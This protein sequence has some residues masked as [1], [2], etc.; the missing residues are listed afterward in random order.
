MFFLPLRARYTGYIF[1]GLKK[2]KM[3]ITQKSSFKII[4]NSLNQIKIFKV[5]I[6]KK[7]DSL[8]ILTKFTSFATGCIIFLQPVA[9]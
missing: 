2:Q 5:N 4:T 9:N 8:L 6:Y 1:R 3:I 7:P